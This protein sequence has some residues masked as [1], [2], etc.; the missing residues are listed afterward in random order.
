MQALCPVS[1]SA[2]VFVRLRLNIIRS[3]LRAEGSGRK[4]IEIR[5]PKWDEKGKVKKAGEAR[6]AVMSCFRQD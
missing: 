3:R 6:K 4:E 1:F 5:N 2:L